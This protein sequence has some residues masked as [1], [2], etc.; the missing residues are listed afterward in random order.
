MGGKD[1]GDKGEESMCSGQLWRL[2]KEGVRFLSLGRVVLGKRGG[3]KKR[4]G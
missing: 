4:R 2:E 3:E 1:Q